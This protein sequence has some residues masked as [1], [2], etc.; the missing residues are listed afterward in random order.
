MPWRWRRVGDTSFWGKN[1]N[2]RAGSFLWNFISPRHRNSPY[3]QNALLIN[4]GW[5][6]VK[7]CL[8]RV[9]E[10]PG[11]QARLTPGVSSCPRPGRCYN[12]RAYLT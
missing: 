2:T 6:G 7:E 8:G 5:E 9:G 11:R 3:I 10:G 12:R 4:E 1:G